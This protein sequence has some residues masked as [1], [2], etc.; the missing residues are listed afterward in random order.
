VFAIPVSALAL[1]AVLVRRRLA[2]AGGDKGGHRR[3]WE[4]QR[5]GDAAAPLA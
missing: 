4:E 2:R 5:G 3:L 1:V